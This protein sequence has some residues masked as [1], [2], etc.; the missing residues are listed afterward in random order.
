MF[1]KRDHSS[2]YEGL[3]MAH[4]NGQPRAWYSSANTT[5][6][7]HWDPWHHSQNCVLLPHCPFSHTLLVNAYFTLPSASVS[8]SAK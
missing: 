7:L 2:V 3:A 5:P 4:R 1:I 6:V 8:T